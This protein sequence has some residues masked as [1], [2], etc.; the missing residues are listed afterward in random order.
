[1]SRSDRPYI[2]TEKTYNANRIV[3]PLGYTMVGYGPN[4][5]HNGAV[6]TKMYELMKFIPTRLNNV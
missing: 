2:P 3:R 4:P 1:V 5:M 6:Y